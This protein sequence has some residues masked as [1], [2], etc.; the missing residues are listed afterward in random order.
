MTAKDTA[1]NLAL[2]LRTG[3]LSGGVGRYWE[4]QSISYLMKWNNMR[5]KNLPAEEI[6][7]DAGE[8]APDTGHILCVFE[9]K[10]AAR[11]GCVIA[12]VLSTAV[13]F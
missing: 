10:R 7:E 13:V 5:E 8:A 11:A 1:K 9:R 6:M 3:W 4:E 2:R 12:C